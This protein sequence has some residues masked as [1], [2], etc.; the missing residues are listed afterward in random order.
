MSHQEGGIPSLTPEEKALR[1]K[2]T[3]KTGSRPSTSEVRKLVALEKSKRESSY[4]PSVITT[5]SMSIDI[6]VAEGSIRKQ[7]SSKKSKLSEV[8]K[9]RM[10]TMPELIMEGVARQRRTPSLYQATP[11]SQSSKKKHP[12]ALTKLQIQNYFKRW[13]ATKDLNT[14][15]KLENGIQYK[16]NILK[17]TVDNITAKELSLIEESKVKYERILNE[18]QSMINSLKT[19]TQKESDEYAILTDEIDKLDNY[20]TNVLN[21][22]YEKITKK[23][24]RYNGLIKF[25][26]S[27][28]QTVTA[29]NMVDDTTVEKIVAVI[30]AGEKMDVDD[31]KNSAMDLDDLL[32]GLM[33]IKIGGGDCA[34]PVSIPGLVG[35]NTSFVGA[36]AEEVAS[37]PAPIEGGKKKRGGKKTQKG[38]EVVGA[39]AEE[40]ASQPA[41]MEGGKKKRGGKKTQKGGEVVGAV[42]EEVASQPAPMEGGKKKRAG[43]K[44]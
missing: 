21:P 34:G 4:L 41:P 43:K 39:V 8:A 13:S 1:S 31:S 38:G 44:N 27:L 15:V 7:K 29:N 23:I 18:K 36:V 37:Q 5:T 20:L 40:V 25:Y 33:G 42:A 26:E 10:S 28:Y 30:E 16:I 3:R 19:R 24:N 2:L 6:P 11:S 12:D 32:S 35:K 17:Q 14:K 22:K 9:L